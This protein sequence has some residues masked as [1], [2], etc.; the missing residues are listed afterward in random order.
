M[1]KKDKKDE[2]YK[3]EN[4][5]NEPEQDDED[6]GLPDLDDDSDSSDSDEESS[7]STEDSEQDSTE[8][9]DELFTIDQ[10]DEYDP[11]PF[12]DDDKEGDELDEEPAST[13]TPPKKQSAAPIIITLSIIVIIACALVYYFFLREPEKEPVAQEPV[14]DTTSYVVEKPVEPEPEVIEPEPEPTEG[15]VNTLNS[16]TG[17]S[18]VVVGSFFDEDLAKDYADKLTKD[19]TNAYI[20]PPFGKSKFNRV[21]IEETESFAQASTRATELSGQFKEQPWP[22]KY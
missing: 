13:Y 5:H 22:L 18:Y 21:A 19:G 15:V 7:S 2:E 10:D 3:D 16:R 9:S 1:A 12:G 11:N 8:T 14:K 4:L 6:F 20:I 17:R